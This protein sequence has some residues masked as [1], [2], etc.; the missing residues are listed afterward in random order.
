MTET[1]FE[2]SYMHVSEL[3]RMGAAITVDGNIANIMGVSGLKGAPVM[4]TD[5]RAS[6]SLVLAG[7]AAQGETV[8]NRLYHLDRGYEGLEDKLIGVGA[9]IKRVSKRA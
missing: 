5:L 7:L 4:A 6:M 3:S 1:I 9:N 2:N 8:V